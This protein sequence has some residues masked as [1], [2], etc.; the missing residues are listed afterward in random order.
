M[1]IYGIGRQI[2][3]SRRPLKTKSMCRN[4]GHSLGRWQFPVISEGDGMTTYEIDELT[5]SHEVTHDSGK[6][7]IGSVR[8]WILSKATFCPVKSFQSP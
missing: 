2:E 8:T 5:Q 3:Q 4:T 1:R 6:L 7:Q